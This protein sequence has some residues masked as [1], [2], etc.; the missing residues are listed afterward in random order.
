[1][2]KDPKAVARAKKAWEHVD[3][4]NISQVLADF[5]HAVEIGKQGS[6]KALKIMI[7]SGTDHIGT[8]TVAKGG[9]QWRFGKKKYPQMNWRQFADKMTS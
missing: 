2:T 4:W 7:W 5:P 9:V 6:R 8:L 1:M 3:D